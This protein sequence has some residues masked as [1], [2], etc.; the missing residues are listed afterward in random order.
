MTLSDTLAALN[1]A[2][3][4]IVAEIDRLEREYGFDRPMYQSQYLMLYLGDLIRF[5]TVI[6]E[7]TEAIRTGQLVP[8]PSVDS[9]RSALIDRLGYAERAEKAVALLRLLH[10]ESPAAIS[11]DDP[12]LE[13]FCDDYYPTDT[14]NALCD[15]GLIDQ[16]GSADF[17]DYRAVLLPDGAAVIAAMQEKPE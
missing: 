8:V 2:A 5:R 14:F 11:A 6:K 4:P 7:I 9:L 15:I 12:R 13:P 10:D 1:E 17:D 3:K 16:I